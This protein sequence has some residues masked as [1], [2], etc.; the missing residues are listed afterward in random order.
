MNQLTKEEWDSY[1]LDL[2]AEELFS[3]LRKQFLESLRNESGR[4]VI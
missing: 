4:C 3:Y 2:M 1:D